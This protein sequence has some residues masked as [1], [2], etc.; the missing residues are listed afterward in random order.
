MKGTDSEKPVLTGILSNVC[1]NSH[2]CV[3]PGPLKI[4]VAITSYRGRLHGAEF[5][6]FALA[7]AYHWHYFQRHTG[8]HGHMVTIWD[9]I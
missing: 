2:E 4:A 9:R 1:L 6:F 8:L 5:Y 7:K 3:I